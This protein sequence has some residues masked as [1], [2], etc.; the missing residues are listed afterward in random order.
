MMFCMCVCVYV[1]CNL[2]ARQNILSQLQHK[3]IPVGVKEQINREWE[4]RI[5]QGHKSTDA[6]QAL[7]HLRHV[8][9]FNKSLSIWPW[10]ESAHSS[11]VISPTSPLDLHT[12]LLRTQCVFMCASDLPAGVLPC[13]FL[14]QIIGLRR[15]KFHS[16]EE[17]VRRPI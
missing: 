13:K 5:K 6:S 15:V 14:A 2:L 8:I 9:C 12:G 7:P 11:R 1:T 10:F 4:V 17:S 16:E 3:Q